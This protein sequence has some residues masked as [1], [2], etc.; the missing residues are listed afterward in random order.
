[1]ER[2]AG[3]APFPFERTSFGVRRTVRHHSDRQTVVGNPPALIR[4]GA[5]GQDAPSA[6]LVHA[7][8]FYLSDQIARGVEPFCKVGILGKND[9]LHARA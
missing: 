1:M 4:N 8:G 6:A 2:A 3:A 7:V 5:P 9:V